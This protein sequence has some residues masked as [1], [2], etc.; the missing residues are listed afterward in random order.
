MGRNAPH[1]CAIV[2]LCAGESDALDGK[3]PVRTIRG[4]DMD[5]APGDLVLLAGVDTQ[6]FGPG[7]HDLLRFIDTA[8][9]GS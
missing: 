1:E 2:V 4:G 3:L 6:E 8:A 5:L 7:L 9:A